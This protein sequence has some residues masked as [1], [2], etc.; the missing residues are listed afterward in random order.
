VRLAYPAVSNASTATNRSSPN[1]LR[2]G[3]VLAIVAR[4]RSRALRAKADALFKEKQTFGAVLKIDRVNRRPSDWSQQWGRYAAHRDQWTSLMACELAK[5][6]PNVRFIGTTL[7]IF[8]IEDK[9]GAVQTVLDECPW[10]DILGD[11]FRTVE[12]DP[13]DPRVLD[14]VLP[15]MGRLE[16][17]KRPLIAQYA[18]QTWD[19]QSARLQP[20]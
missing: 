17:S 7:G 19:G 11:S 2:P 18:G 20:R 12:C 13:Q 5:G 14:A 3:F 15:P 9:P 8:A 1:D 16:G 4:R 6:F 10:R